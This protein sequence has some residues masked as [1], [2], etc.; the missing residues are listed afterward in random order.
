MCTELHRPGPVAVQ[1]QVLLLEWSW[2]GLPQG[3]GLHGAEHSLGGD[4]SIPS[5]PT[6]RIAKVPSLT[7]LGVK[8]ISEVSRCWT[9]C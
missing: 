6:F 3:W 7:I 9:S 8:V 5:S 4:I 1:A 2:D